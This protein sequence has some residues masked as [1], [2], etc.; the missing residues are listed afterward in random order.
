[1]RERVHVRVC[2]HMCVCACRPLHTRAEHRAGVDCARGQCFLVWSSAQ[3]LLLA[4]RSSSRPC[5]F[6]WKIPPPSPEPVAPSLGLQR[7]IPELA[8]R[9]L[10]PLQVRTL[11]SVGAPRPLGRPVTLL[12]RHFPRQ[13]QIR[14]HS[15]PGP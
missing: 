10:A 3:K 2:V 11:S 9:A 14:P 8:A 15:P 6:P 1:M 5:L 13:A 7:V 12:S 4:R